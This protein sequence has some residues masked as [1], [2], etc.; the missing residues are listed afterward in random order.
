V[1]SESVDL[2]IL[3]IVS[4]YNDDSGIKIIKKDIPEETWGILPSCRRYSSG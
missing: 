2:N 4:C 1:K 3:I